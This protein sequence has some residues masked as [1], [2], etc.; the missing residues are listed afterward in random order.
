M[1]KRKKAA[2]A[3]AVIFKRVYRV[4]SDTFEKMRRILQKE[5]DALR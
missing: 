5:H 1:S 4:K 2:D 3:K